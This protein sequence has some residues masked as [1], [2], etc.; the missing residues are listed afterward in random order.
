MGKDPSTLSLSP[1]KVDTFFGC[2]RLFKY[3]YL[4]P[5]FPPPPNRYFLIGNIAHKA[6][7][8]FHSNDRLTHLRGKKQLKRMRAVMSESFKKAVYK[9]HAYR[10]IKKGIISTDDLYAIREMLLKYL[11]YIKS[12]SFPSVLHVERLARFKI[13]GIPISMKADRID[14]IGHKAYRIVDYKSGRAATKRAELQSVQLPTYGIW[15][16]SLYPDAKEIV[17]EYIYLKELGSRNGTHEHTI[18]T[19]MMEEAKDKFREVRRLLTNGCEFMQNFK[20]KYC[21]FCDYRR[22]CLEDENNGFP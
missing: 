13:D 7:E 2:R 8:L 22:Y 17:G 15:I 6:L 12:T 16:A 4:L 3:N 18:T 14:H 19:A 10:E 9:Y 21:N 11:R 1:T 20:Y 5:P